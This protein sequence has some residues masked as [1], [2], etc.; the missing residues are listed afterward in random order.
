MFK[1]MNY[2]PR[3]LEK[4]AVDV[5]KLSTNY[6]DIISDGGNSHKCKHTPPL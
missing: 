1:A 5:A 3:D 6:Y 4:G 2:I